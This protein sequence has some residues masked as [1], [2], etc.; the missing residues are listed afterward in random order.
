MKKLSL[1][2]FLFSS[3]T[4]AQKDKIDSLYRILKTTKSDSIKVDVYNK[5]AWGFL[6]NDKEKASE[7]LNKT[8]NY[9]LKTNQKYGYNTFLNSKGIFYDVNGE[10]DSAL[11]YF[12]KSLLYSQ[13]NKFPTQEQYTYNN[14]GMY[15]WNKGEYKS[16]LTSFFKALKLAESNYL[17]DTTVKIDATLNN[18]GLIYQEMELYEKAIPY[19]QRA[20]KIRTAKKR[21]QGEAASF[22][23]L[24]ICFKH[25]GDIQKAK[26]YF[27][28]GIKKANEVQDMVLYYNNLQ[29]LAGVYATENQNQK[30]LD[31]YLESY[32]RPSNIP[33]N[34][35]AK[36]KTLGSISTL[37]YNLNQPVKS[38]EYGELG[39]QEIAK[40]DPSEVYEVGIYKTLS[41]A[42]FMIGNSDKGNH[43]SQL[44]YDKTIQ[45]FKESSAKSLQELEVKYESEMNELAL[46]KAKNENLIKAS[47]LRQ[48]NQIIFGAFGLAFLLGLIGFLVFKQQKLKNNQ[49]AKEN[50]LRQALTKIETQNKLQNQRLEISRELHDNIGSQLTFIISS[51]DNLKFYNLTK[52]GLNDKYDKISGFTRGTINELR[53]SIWAMNKEEIT[54]ED[55]KYR[56]ANFIEN[57][58][59]SMQGI[60]FKFTYPQDTSEIGLNSK[61]GI[62]I[63][64][65]IQEAVNN[66]IKHA[67]ASE[68]FV[69]I[70]KDNEIIL[71][72]VKDNG[73][74]FYF[75]LVEKNNGIIS[76]QNRAKEIDAKIEFRNN[77]G[78]EVV[79]KVPLAGSSNFK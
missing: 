24:G 75:E 63:Y 77:N 30:S 43:Y 12:N 10:A 20:L 59:I 37:Y 19:H 7:L 35:N 74:G 46:V 14:L 52:E 36:V 67:G 4:Y 31:L 78:T 60:D 38:I 69:H 72:H 9:A 41:T 13:K 27:Q 26:T 56:T 23:N 22:N 49:L 50:D 53:D 48:K 8:E 57:A 6:F 58:N 16:A 71:V 54:F 61:T 62:Y 42:Y 32:N 29:G 44:F 11:I 3:F 45:R 17:Q 66:A 39:I 64:R 68:V 40:Q 65:I 70:E 25:L 18:I 15:A 79:L 34:S 33:Y 55:L 76:M 21:A 47:S 1:L 28:K 73:Q 51:I 2:L 5:L